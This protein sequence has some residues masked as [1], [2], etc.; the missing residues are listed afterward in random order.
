MSIKITRLCRGLSFRPSDRL[1]I[2]FLYRNYDAGYSTFHGKGPGSSSSTNNE[3]GILGNFTFE[4]AKHLFVSGGFDN[5]YFPWLKYRCSSPSWGRREELRIRFLP[6]DKLTIDGCYNYKFSMVDSLENN[7][8]PQQKQ[9][10][11][12]CVKGS[13]RYSIYDNLTLGTRIDYKVVDPSGSSGTMLLQ[14]V[15]YRFRHIPIVLWFRYCL[16]STDDWDSRIYTYENDLLYSYSVPAFSGEGSRSYIMVKWEIKDFAE[17]RIKYS[18][19]TKNNN[20]NKPEDTDELK[21][22]FKVMF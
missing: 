14:D 21:M 18:I 19:T 20:E 5:Q 1:T 6:V 4:A 22:Q 2:N 3:Q 13:A 7:G 17:V 11:A 12:R 10:V 8:V 15:N 16:F 9:I